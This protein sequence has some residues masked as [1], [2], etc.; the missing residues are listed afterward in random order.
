M[1]KVF[2]DDYYTVVAES[3][4]QAVQFFLDQELTD[5]EGIEY[6]EEVDPD[7]K[8]MFFPLDELP[9]EFHD[10][11]K[12]PREDWCGHYVGVKITLTEAMKY[13]KEEAPYI[14]CVSS[15]LA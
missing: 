4:E 9:E 8:T 7:K 15:E 13:S 2:S 12:Y 14:I 3:R 11:K 10:E 1:P 5:G 6:I